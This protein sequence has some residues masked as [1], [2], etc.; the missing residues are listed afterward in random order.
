M[1]TTDK[2]HTT[3]M[4]LL[5]Q[6]MD[7]LPD[8][9]IGKLA[10]RIDWGSP[11]ARVL[12][13][14][15][16]AIVDHDSKLDLLVEHGSDRVAQIVL[17]GDVL[18][19]VG[20]ARLQQGRTLTQWRM[21]FTQ[22]GLW[23]S[24]CMQ[25]LYRGRIGLAQQC[26]GN[27]NSG[28]ISLLENLVT[29]G[30]Q[31]GHRHVFEFMLSDQ[32]LENFHMIVGPEKARKKE[33]GS[34]RKGATETIAL[35]APVGKLRSLAAISGGYLPADCVAAAARHNEKPHRAFAL[36]RL[37][38]MDE[39]GSIPNTDVDVD[40]GTAMQATGLLDLLVLDLVEKTNSV[41]DFAP[42]ARWL[43]GR[44][45]AARIP[46]LVG[47]LAR[48]GRCWDDDL[49]AAVRS[50]CP[51]PGAQEMARLMVDASDTT[52]EPRLNDAL[53]SWDEPMRTGLKRR[54]EKMS[55]ADIR[56]DLDA[57][58]VARRLAGLLGPGHG[59]P[60]FE[61]ALVEKQSWFGVG[62]GAQ[63]NITQAMMDEATVGSSTGTKPRRI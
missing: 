9:E 48:N 20:R 2:T 30:A 31:G 57:C 17:E 4:A 45:P 50:V 49:L 11:E 46:A 41:R 21:S 19:H 1:A 53:Q 62:A 25:A 5:I 60:A 7:K 16:H 23:A 56:N 36:A 39:N 54:L 13:S 35:Y 24:A 47:V 58:V 33:M 3:P 37:V 14:G 52:W 43:L 34:L 59:C 38:R 28:R 22:D 26:L 12:R 29:A 27:I 10:A 63:A 55:Q 18:G 6:G 40:L 61:A 15:N 32:F 42:R 44:C 51:T 8:Q